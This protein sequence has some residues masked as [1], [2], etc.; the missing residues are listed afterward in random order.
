ML[1]NVYPGIRPFRTCLLASALAL[2]GAGVAGPAFA[3]TPYD[4]H[5]SVVITTRA[6]ACEP[7][8]RYGVEILDGSVVNSTGSNQADVSGQVSRRGI[9]RVSVRAGGAW[10][11][12]SG[13]LGMYNGSGVWRGEGSSGACEGTWEAERRGPAGETANPGPIYS[14]EP[15]AE[16]TGTV[17]PSVACERFRSYD[18][19]TGTYLGD[20]GVR[21]S[22]R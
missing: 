14:Y 21:H 10:A 4:G 16:T 7:T 13:R 17:A 12:G 18:P 8:V 20:N 3:S 19:A 5:W 11:D 1:S 9:M 2:A 6:G 22:C 15:G